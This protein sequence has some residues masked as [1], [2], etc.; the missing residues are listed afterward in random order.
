M[1]TRKQIELFNLSFELMESMVMYQ[2]VTYFSTQREVSIDEV[3]REISE[4]FGISVRVMLSE[5]RERIIKDARFFAIYFSQR[6][7]PD[8]TSVGLG[9]Y[10]GGRD[11]TTILHAAEVVENRLMSEDSRYLK[12][13]RELCDRFMIDADDD[14]IVV[15]YSIDKRSKRRKEKVKRT[16]QANIKKLQHKVLYG[17]AI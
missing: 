13:H 3:L 2:K 10:F 5:S 14:L 17:K 6:L 9:E 1:I 15:R 8:T 7:L 12:F 16:Y 4:Y 11:H